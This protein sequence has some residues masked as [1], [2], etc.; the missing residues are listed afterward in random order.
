MAGG[1]C[2]DDTAVPWKRLMLCT[3]TFLRHTPLQVAF[4]AAAV[5]VTVTVLWVG[6]ALL[7]KVCRLDPH[8][9]TQPHTPHALQRHNHRQRCISS[10][11]AAVVPACSRF[12]DSKGPASLCRLRKCTLHRH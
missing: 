2:Q 8:V 4:V 11:Y 3:Y 1:A 6:V 5:V 7:S 10:P 9:Q 12:Q